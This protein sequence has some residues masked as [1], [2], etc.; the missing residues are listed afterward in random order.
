MVVNILNSHVK[1]CDTASGDG[2]RPFLNYLVL[3]RRDK[4]ISNVLTLHN[5]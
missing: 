2:E 3:A 5:C 1:I 4:S